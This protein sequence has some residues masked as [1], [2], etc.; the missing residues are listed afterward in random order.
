MIKALLSISLCLRQ[1]VVETVHTI[2][3]VEGALQ[4]GAHNTGTG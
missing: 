2:T 1:F 4:G 3:F